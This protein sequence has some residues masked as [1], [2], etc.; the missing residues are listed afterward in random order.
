MDSRS[1]WP[2]LRAGKADQEQGLEL[3]RR[4]Y[5]R[6][7]SASHIMQLGIALLWLKQYAQAW[8][9]F[10]T[11]T[12]RQA[13]KWTSNKSE[14]FY[15]MAGVAKWCLGERHEAIAEWVPGLKADYGSAGG[16][17]IPL[18]LFFAS[19]ISPELYN[20]K[21]VKELMLEKAKDVRIKAWPGPIVRWILGQVN[22]GEF[23]MLCQGRD[24]CDLRDNLW[25]A[26]FYRS[27]MRFERSK[28]SNFRE[29]MNKLTDLQQPEWQDQDAFLSRIWKEE[30]FLARHE[31]AEIGNA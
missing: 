18:L 22:G 26:E 24:K 15:G 9:H 16:V 23:L 1:V 28:I 11:I 4:A 12:R 5:A 29:S 3:C 2:L 20:G 27:L 30:Y 25:Q 13:P 6:D 14:S 8:E 19:V 17:K 21:T 7:P 31:A 10:S